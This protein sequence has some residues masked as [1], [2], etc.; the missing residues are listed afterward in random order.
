MGIHVYTWREGVKSQALFS[1]A[2]W[3]EKRQWAKTETQEVLS[4]HKKTLYHHKSG[5]EL[6]LFDQRGCEVSLPGG[7]QKLSECGP[8]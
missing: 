5:W 1:S 8:K 3:Q 4:E 6:T 2:Q 7:I